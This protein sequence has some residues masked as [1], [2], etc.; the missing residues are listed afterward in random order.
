MATHYSILALKIP[1]MEEP[2]TDTRGHEVAKSWTRLSH[3]TFITQK[4]AFPR[5]HGGWHPDMKLPA[6]R[7]VRKKLLLFITTCQSV[8]SSF[9]R[10]HGLQLTRLLCPWDSPDKNTGADCHS[11]LQRIFLT[12]GSNPGLLHCRQ[13][14]YH[15]SYREVLVYST[16]LP[17]PELRYLPNHHSSIKA[18]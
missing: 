1:W 15:L 5:T 6:S 14:F 3:F 8:L 4:R 9:L 16:L 12:Q 13:I 2:W 18:Q 11:F 10:P 7:T 17:Q